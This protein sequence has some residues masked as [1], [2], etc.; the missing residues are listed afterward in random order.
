MK[1]SVKD[2]VSYVGNGSPRFYLPLDQQLFNDNFAQFVVVTHDTAAREDL[3]LRLEAHFAS[4][5][6][7]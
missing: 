2:F 6:A 1:R 4:E 3:K 5:N 7:E